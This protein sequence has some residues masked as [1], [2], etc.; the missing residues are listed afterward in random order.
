MATSVDNNKATSTITQPSSNIT[1]NEGIN[2]KNKEDQLQ[3]L[4]THFKTRS[5]RLFQNPCFIPSI[6]KGVIIGSGLGLIRSF[7]FK[8]TFVQ[9]ESSGFVIKYYRNSRINWLY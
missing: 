7:I 5:K 3:G 8:S 6:L 2:I 4:F 1:L 9:F